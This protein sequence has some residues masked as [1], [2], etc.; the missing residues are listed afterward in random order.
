MTLGDKIIRR[1]AQTPYGLK[2]AVAA[3]LAAALAVANPK[4]L[5][6]AVGGAVSIASSGASAGSMTVAA[7][8][9]VLIAP[10]CTLA[11]LGVHLLGGDRSAHVLAG[12]KTWMARHNAAIMTTLLIVLGTKYVGDDISGLAH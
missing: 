1:Q 11:P 10:L 5:V 6:L 3:G 7:V 12:W 2:G 9:M 8:L 4:N